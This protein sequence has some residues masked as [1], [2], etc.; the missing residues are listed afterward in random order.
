MITMKKKI[1][2]NNFIQKINIKDNTN[3]DYSKLPL[4]EVKSNLISLVNGNDYSTIINILKPNDL[5]GSPI[6]TIKN[7]V[8]LF[9]TKK[10]IQD[11]NVEVNLL[12]NNL[13]NIKKILQTINNFS[14]ICDLIIYAVCDN[15]LIG[16][17]TDEFIKVV[18]LNNNNFNHRYYNVLLKG[19][20]KNI[21]KYF[22]TD[23]KLIFAYLLTNMATIIYHNSIYHDS[24][25]KVFYQ[26]LSYFFY[27]LDNKLKSIEYKNRKEEIKNYLLIE[28]MVLI[29]V[30]HI[31]VADKSYVHKFIPSILMYKLNLKEIDGEGFITWL[32]GVSGN[33]ARAYKEEL[34]NTF[35]HFLIGVKQFDINV[36]PSF[37]KDI[38]LGNKN[39]FELPYN[40]LKYFKDFS[41]KYKYL[42]PIVEHNIRIN[43]INSFNNENYLFEH[44][45]LELI[46][47][48]SLELLVEYYNI[49]GF[50]V[51]ILKLILLN[52]VVLKIAA[53][54]AEIDV[55]FTNK[56]KIKKFI[57]T[58]NRDLYRE[59]LL[60]TNLYETKSYKTEEL[61]NLDNIIIDLLN[62]INTDANDY[63]IKDLALKQT[64]LIL[65]LVYPHLLFNIIATRFNIFELYCSKIIAMI[66]D[67]PLYNSMI[68][69][70]IY[71]FIEEHA[72]RISE[73]FKFNIITDKNIIL[74][75]GKFDYYNSKIKQMDD[76]DIQQNPFSILE[77]DFDE[78]KEV[79]LK[80]M[81]N[82][83]KQDINNLYK[84]RLAQL[85]I[86]NIQNRF[87]Y[88][89]FGDKII[90]SNKQ[91]LLDELSKFVKD[92]DI[93]EL[94][95]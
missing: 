76:F 90:I 36:Q 86:F 56:S 18:K 54:F 93:M 85:N 50:D 55:S 69:K 48:Q 87:V 61:I 89:I 6:N 40:S 46:N 22:V 81:N 2:K 23:N 71:R 39:S 83:I 34:Y 11:I 68:H 49:N 65:N 72:Q 9:V 30:L 80:A 8:L 66:V 26:G 4:K 58:I 51:T 21:D 17:K 32:N 7:K 28:S 79:I 63:D 82:K 42:Q 24:I 94:L 88:D 10:I 43:I 53:I 62:F 38:I 75:L 15:L 45:D 67:N 74:R 5:I 35:L 44:D 13:Y 78:K 84:Y 33:L 19:Y 1:N 14:I 41:N 47:M 52:Q 73:H 25:D 37:I 57:K 77:V 92:S 59:Q 12:T 64:K 27:I 3:F 70:N 20:L 95:S 29:D 91:K 60:L 31:A 16:N